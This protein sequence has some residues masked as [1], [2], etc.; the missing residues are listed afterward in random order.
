MDWLSLELMAICL[1]YL[2]VCCPLLPL[3]RIRTL[4]AQLQLKVVDGRSRLKVKK[5]AGPCRAPKYRPGRRRRAVTLT[6]RGRG[7]VHHR[8]R[9]RCWAVGWSHITNAKRRLESET[10]FCMVTRQRPALLW[11]LIGVG[12]SSR[13]GSWR[14]TNAAVVVSRK[15]GQCSAEQLPQAMLPLALALMR[16]SNASGIHC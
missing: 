5:C 15:S 12:E 1:R 8:A 6:K 3:V 13:I 2:A 14:W 9:C 16:T 10:R 4:L 7:P 11:A